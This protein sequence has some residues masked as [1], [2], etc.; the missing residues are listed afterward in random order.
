MDMSVSKPLTYHSTLLP[1]LSL[2]LLPY[3][4][5]SVSDD[6]VALMKVSG[7]RLVDRVVQHKVLTARPP[8]SSSSSS[9]LPSSACNILVL[10]VHSFCNHPYISFPSSFIS[11]SD[12]SFLPHLSSLFPAFSIPHSALCSIYLSLSLS[13]ISSPLLPLSPP[14][15]VSLSCCHSHCLNL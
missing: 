15:P 13:I 7:G 6:A 12:A 3:L 11:S 4:P 9:V 8:S 10:C 2:P 1:G 5:H 14:Y